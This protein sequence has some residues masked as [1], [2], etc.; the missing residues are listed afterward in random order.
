MAYNTNSVERKKEKIRKVKQKNRSIH[1]YCIIHII[2]CIS[3]NDMQPFHSISHINEF[4]KQID[5]CLDQ[6]IEITKLSLQSYLTFDIAFGLNATLAFRV[7]I[8]TKTE[9]GLHNATFTILCTINYT[10]FDLYK[11][12]ANLWKRSLNLIS[13]V[14]LSANNAKITPLVIIINY[15]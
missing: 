1:N 9:Q 3:N 15:P 14:G 6:F 11:S 13:I 5:L 2:F 10:L 12:L 7:T 4:F 8:I